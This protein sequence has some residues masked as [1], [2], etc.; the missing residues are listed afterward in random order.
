M[1]VFTPVFYILI[2]RI[3]LDI[4]VEDT[5]NHG[6]IYMTVCLDNR[7]FI[8]KIKM[9]DIDKTPGMALEQFRKKG[10]A[11]KY[12]ESHCEIFLSKC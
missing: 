4:R 1:K 3:G 12:Q 8:C 11:D 7:V 10:Y 5:T 9:T 2:L 6:R